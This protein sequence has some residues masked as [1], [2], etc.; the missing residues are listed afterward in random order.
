[1]VELRAD[2]HHREEGD[3]GLRQ[4]RHVQPDAVARPHVECPQ[5]ADMPPAECRAAALKALYYLFSA[6]Y[7]N[8]GWPQF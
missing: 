1:M 8:G 7:P 3:E 6:Q 5:R 2:L 4:V